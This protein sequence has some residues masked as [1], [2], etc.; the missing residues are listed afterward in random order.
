MSAPQST[1]PDHAVAEFSSRR[2]Q[3]RGDVRFSFQE[4]GGRPSYVLEDVAKR[5][6]FQVGLPEYHFLRSLD[7]TRTVRELLGRSARVSGQAALGESQAQSILRWA[8]DHELL[9]SENVDQ[10]DRRGQHAVDQEKKRPKQIL[11]EVLFLKLPL[12]NPDPFLHLANRWLGWIAAPWFFVVWLVVVLGASYQ[13]AVHWRPFMESAGGAILPDNWLLL[14]ITFSL[15]KLIHELGHGIVAKRFKV[16]VPEWGVRLLAFISPLTYVD[17]SASWRLTTRWPRICVAGAGMYVELLVAAI[18]VFVWVE[19]DPGLINTLA[20]NSIFA[21]SVVT[22][23]FNANPLMRFDGYYILS[24]LLQIPNL[25]MKGQRMMGWFGKKYLL[26]MKDEILPQTIAERGWVIGT[27]GFAAS[28]WKVVIWVGIMS[29]ASSLF[30]GAGI[31]IVFAA[32][33]GS[34]I[35]TVKRFFTF[36]GSSLGRLN[37]KVASLRIAGFAALI[38]LPF[39]LIPVS[40]SPKMATV[41]HHPEK[42]VMRVESPGFVTEVLCHNGQAVNEGEVLVKLEN[43]IKTAELSQLELDVR[44]SETQSRRWFDEGH[45]A[46]Y[47]SELENLKALEKR[48]ESTRE[49]VETL[50]I[51]API[52]GIVHGDHIGNLLGRF[53]QAGDTVVTV[54][55]NDP[56][57]LLVTI[58][59]DEIDAVR[60]RRDDGIKVHLR[61]HG[62]EVSAKLDRLEARATTALPHLALGA[63]SGGPLALRQRATMQ[64]DRKRGLARERFPAGDGGGAMGLGNDSDEEALAG[65]ELV[66]PRIIAHAIVDGDESAFANLKEGEWGYAKLTG[67]QQYRLGEWVYDK[68]A[69][70]VKRQFD[71]ARNASA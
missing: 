55:P 48:L 49:L 46:S 47:Q 54:I 11:Q 17:A 30:K 39:I 25:A 44:K 62:A 15:L 22:V 9:E 14:I 58:G 38:I 41:V 71:R 16:P 53:L 37:P 12:G 34:V 20:Y 56:P 63:I 24:D 7:G 19:T 69:G 59:E 29:M 3:L 2:P 5:K 52:A 50:E 27:Y 57:E 43:R 51:R 70:W 42:A 45:I 60:R 18:T 65:Q 67:G 21:A 8:I 36:L 35:S 13:M 31:V 33:M 4:H 68:M 1:L 61:G 66:R 6:Y 23:L 28:I 26:G 64:S 10:D 40:P 32:L